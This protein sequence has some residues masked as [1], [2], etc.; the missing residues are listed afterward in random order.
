MARQLSFLFLGEKGRST[1]VVVVV[2][3]VQASYFEIMYSVF[4]W[5]V[6]IYSELK[7]SEVTSSALKLYLCSFYFRI[8]KRNCV[9][10]KKYTVLYAQTGHFFPEDGLKRLPPY[11]YSIFVLA[12]CTYECTTHAISEWITVHT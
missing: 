8:P 11:T 9:N 4:I 2:V 12:A 10:L 6:V 1:V 7:A 3:L 5:I